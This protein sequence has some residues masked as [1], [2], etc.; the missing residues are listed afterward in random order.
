MPSR[1]EIMA[2]ASLPIQWESTLAAVRVTPSTTTPG[3][4]TPT[5]PDQLKCSTTC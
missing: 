3:K 2:R 5:G 4:V 1:S